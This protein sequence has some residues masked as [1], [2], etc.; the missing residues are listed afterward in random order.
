MAI[1]T[2]EQLRALYAQPGERALRKQMAQL[3]VHAQRFIALAPFCVLASAGAGGALLDAS[4]RGGTPGFVKVRDAQTLLLPDSGGNNR[5]DTLHNLIDDPR[6]ALIFMIPGVDETLRVNGAARLRE[7][8]EFTGLFA[9]ERQRPK[10][11]IE[12][13]VQE[14]YLHCAKAF[15]RSQLWQPAT[16]GPRDALPSMGRMIGDQIGAGFVGESDSETMAR[17]RAQLA[18]E[19]RAG[20]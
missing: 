3:D 11:V 17:Y 2:R 10:L 13:A 15:M 20:N 1:T 4:P 19:A 5:L 6:A 18:A 8:D 9:Q 7:E 14:A 16:W 12:I